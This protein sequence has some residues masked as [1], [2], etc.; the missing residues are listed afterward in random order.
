MFLQGCGNIEV[1]GVGDEDSVG[2]AAC[3][4]DSDCTTNVSCEIGTCNKS[5]GT[6]SYV[7]TEGKCL[8]DGTCYG[9][10]QEEPGLRCKVC[11]S[12][13]EQFGFVNKT[14]E[15][16]LTCDNETGE[17]VAVPTAGCGDGVIQDTETCDDANNVGG[18]G[19]SEACKVEAGYE[20]P[21]EGMACVDVDE[22]AGDPSPCDVHATCTNADGTFSCECNDGFTGDGETCTSEDPCDPNP[23]QHEGVCEAGEEGP[24]CACADGY[25]GTLCEVELNGCDKTPC[26]NGGTCTDTGAGTFSCE[27]VEGYEGDACETDSDNCAAKPCLNGG[28]CVDGLASYTCQCPIGFTGDTCETEVLGCDPNPCQNGGECTEKGAG[29]YTC[30]CK[31]GYVGPQCET[32]PN[33]CLPKICDNGGL[34][35]DGIDS[36][37][38]ECADGFEGGN[39]ETNI[40]DCDPNPCENGGK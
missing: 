9:D 23:C 17:C 15:G 14:C 19:C 3:T 6:C 20:C 8:V 2:S 7:V 35:I 32:N 24:V 1:V 5:K 38:C 30:A 39:C 4:T 26:L 25:K 27:C 21:T 31:P 40:N 37:T 18:D 36:Y 13:L 12:D 10:G 29:K 22:C 33:D 16:D 34:C 11:R 28:K